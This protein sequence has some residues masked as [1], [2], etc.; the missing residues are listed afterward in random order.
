MSFTSLTSPEDSPVSNRFLLARIPP[1]AEMLRHVCVCCVQGALSL[2]TSDD[3]VMMGSGGCQVKA[4]EIIFRR[5][6][7]M[8]LSLANVLAVVLEGRMHVM[9]FRG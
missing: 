4:E 3:E 9:K 6:I 5:Q 2:V 8:E 7:L 1:F